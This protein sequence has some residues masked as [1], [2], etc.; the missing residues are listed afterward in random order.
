MQGQAQIVRVTNGQNLQTL[1]NNAT[2]GTTFIVEAGSYG[3][4]SITKRIA[5]IGPGYLLNSNQPAT[6]GAAV[7]GNIY[8]RVGSNNSILM[9]CLVNQ[10]IS[11]AASQVTI[12][13]CY[14][15][16]I[17][18]GFDYVM[19]AR[20][21]TNNNTVKQCY[22]TNAISLLSPSAI[23]V[24]N[25]LVRNA[26]AF[27]G[28][29]SGTIQNNTFWHPDGSVNYS[30]DYR[31]S[32]FINI[33]NNIA[34][35]TWYSVPANANLVYNVLYSNQAGLPS[36]NKVN[37]PFASVFVGGSTPALESQF[38]LSASSPAKG[39]GENGVDCGAFG[40]DEPYVLGG[41]PTGPVIYEFTLPQT[42]VS[43][44]SLNVLI[45]ARVQN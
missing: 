40:G 12:S 32:T 17:E 18:I 16:I 30:G 21:E 22:V 2:A 36:S 4:L 39:A 3:D 1:I 37:I 8:F 11:I 25:N 38:M 34:K 26:I 7:F 9:S 27:Y 5:I 43:G 42:I 28:L 44:S 15:S 14:A 45:K 19:N 29:I 10:N 6:V 24:K 20:I 13:R 33:K 41:V 35:E 23:T 31:P